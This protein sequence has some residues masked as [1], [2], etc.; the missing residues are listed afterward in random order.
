MNISTFRAFR[1]RNYRLYFSGQSIS[2]IGTWMQ[3]TSVYWL[4]YIQTQSTFM[5]GLTVFAAQFPSFLFSLLGGVL[6]DRYNRYRVLLLTQVLS[7]IQATMLTALI[8]FNQYSVWQI[9]VLNVL[10]GVINAFDVPARQAMV[11]DMVDEKEDLSNAIA[12]NSSMVNLARLLGPAIA[13]IVLEMYGAG[14]CFM[15][16]TLS[17]AAVILSLLLM[18]LPKF[19]P[20]IHT[21]KVMG[22]LKEGFTYLKQTP[23]IGF[24]I[25]FLACASLLVLPFTTLLP[26]YAKVIFKGNAAIFGYLNSAI[27]LGAVSGTIFLASLKPDINLKKIL[28]INTLIFG[29]GLI[30]FS[31]MNNLPVALFF[32]IITGFGMMSQVTVSN[33]ILQTTVS[34]EMRGRVISYFAMAFFGMQPLGGLLVGSVSHYIGT[35]NTILA[36]GVAALLIALLFSYILRKDIFKRREI[37]PLK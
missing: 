26:V 37:E 33:T 10:L 18:R 27:G 3:R 35:P 19:T 11:Y 32:A 12:L 21:K 9:L 16:N 15:I 14:I 17:F 29:A 13:G 25:L 4:V 1:S 36:E 22:E 30:A 34:L 6:S 5:L 7:M 8:L 24:I 20:Q 31:H 28:F 23:S 2:L